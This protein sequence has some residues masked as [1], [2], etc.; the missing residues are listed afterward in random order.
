[1]TSRLIRAR[2]ATDTTQMTLSF[3]PGLKDRHP[4]LRECIA[5]GIYQRGL[6][7]V[8]PSVDYAPGNLSVALSADP[9][10]KF[11]VDEW[12]KYMQEWADYSG[13]YYLVEKYLGEP[14]A[15]KDSALDEVKALAQQMQAAM[16]KAGMV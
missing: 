13:I 15:A 10:R 11:S 2:R 7:K 3:E 6:T 16:R 4:S 8:A 14:E 12:E 9:T 5:T 1:M